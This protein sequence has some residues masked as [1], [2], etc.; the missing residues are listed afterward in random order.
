MAESPINED[1]N[2]MAL[3]VVTEAK[4]QLIREIIRRIV[5]VHQDTLT[6]QE[7]VKW[8]ESSP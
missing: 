2:G 7:E 4:M 1:C 6:N 8:C 3:V 5:A